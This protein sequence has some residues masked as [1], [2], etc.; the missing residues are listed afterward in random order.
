MRTQSWKYIAGSILLMLVSRTEAQQLPE[1]AGKALVERSCE[2]CH[3]L[4]GILKTKATRARWTKIVDDMVARGAE[5]T[6][7]E[8]EIIIDYLA[9][10]F[11]PAA[12][13]TGN[14]EP[15]K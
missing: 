15:G 13:P 3:T 2:K 6:D 4:E 10:N 12:S 5:G 7:R 1:G 9:K 11:G 14:S 8:L